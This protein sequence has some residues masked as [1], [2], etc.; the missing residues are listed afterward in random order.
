M[1]SKKVL[2]ITGLLCLLALIAGSVHRASSSGLVGGGFAISPILSDEWPEQYPAVAYNSIWQEYLVAWQ[3]G[4]PSGNA[5][6]VR[7]LSKQGALIGGRGW[8]TPLTAWNYYADLAYNPA[9]DEYL[10]VYQVGAGGSAICGM[11]LN[12]IG[13]PVGSEQCFGN[14]AGYSYHTPAVAYETDTGYYMVT[15]EKDQGTAFA[16]IEARSLLGDG[17]AMGDTLEITGLVA[18]VHPSEPDIACV[19]TMDGCLIVWAQWYDASFSDRDVRG[20]RIHIDAGSAHREGLTFAIHYTPNDEFNPAIAAVAK[21]TGIGQ[22]LV[23]CD[24]TQTTPS[25]VAVVGELVT[26]SGALEAWTV[27][28][29]RTDTSLFPSVAGSDSAQNY[30]VAWKDGDGIAAQTISTAGIPVG[31]RTTVFSGL[32]PE[33]PATAGGVT[34]DYLITWH[35]RY[36]AEYGQDIFGHLWGNRIFTP[37]VKK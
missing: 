20:Q 10:L 26:D 3:M 22:Y 36:T 18:H 15:W 14:T 31:D 23:V 24:Y 21:T 37:M 32:S 8:V 9:R 34:G 6:Y 30:L 29:K 28:G 17:S 35:A 12:S 19:R 13:S 25:L 7:R 4:N 5:I 27:V 33:Y 16:G 11:R 2:R 1:I